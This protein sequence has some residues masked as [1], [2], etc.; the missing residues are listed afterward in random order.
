MVFPLD[1]RKSPGGGQSSA[2]PQEILSTLQPDISILLKWCMSFV[3]IFFYE[4]IK[5]KA[6]QVIAK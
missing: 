4:R 6:V 1:W 3:I 2:M 5:K